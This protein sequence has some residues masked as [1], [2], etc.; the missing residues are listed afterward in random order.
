MAWPGVGRHGTLAQAS[1]AAGSRGKVAGVTRRTTSAGGRVALARLTRS[2][3]PLSAP[4]MLPGQGD[5]T[6]APLPIRHA[7]LFEP[8][9][10]E[11]IR[12]L[13]PLVVSRAAGRPEHAGIHEQDT[14]PRAGGLRVDRPRGGHQG[15]E[16]PEPPGMTGPP[17]FAPGGR[18][19]LRAP[20]QHGPSPET[21]CRQ[22][23]QDGGP[24]RPPQVYRGGEAAHT[25]EGL[26]R[27]GLGREIRRPPRHHLKRPRLFHERQWCRDGTVGMMGQDQQR[28]LLKMVMGW[29]PSSYRKACAG[30]HVHG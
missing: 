19:D 24:H 23:A 10:G 6:F 5:Q 20:D 15:A 27:A 2:P 26:I 3:Y 14:A 29:Q 17:P 8:A 9:G 22:G 21:P 30:P 16:A 12:Q 25:V 18:R 11:V 28:H 13:Q 7:S 4:A 1:P